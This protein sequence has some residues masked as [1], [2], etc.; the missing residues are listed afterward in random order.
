MSEVFQ[1][2]RLIVRRFERED[3]NALVELGRHPSVS[4]EIPEIPWQDPAKLL[5]YIDGQAALELFAAQKCVDLAIKRKSD[6]RLIGLLSFV[7][8]GARQGKVGWVLGIDQRGRGCAT[9]AARGLIEYAFGVCNYH[10]VS[11]DTTSSN[12]RSRKLMERLGMRQEAY[13]R[14]TDPPDEPGG[15][16]ADVVCYALLASEWPVHS[17]H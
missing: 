14:E 8:N 1:T 3:A 4:S 6:N 17:A 10:R 7:S 11:G 13:F 2:E 5:E 16:W 15:R 12:E 9:E